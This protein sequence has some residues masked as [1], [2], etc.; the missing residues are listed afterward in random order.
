MRKAQILHRKC[1]LNK[2][3]PKFLITLVSTLV[4]LL[5]KQKKTMQLAAIMHY[6]GDE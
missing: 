1:P 4:P 3:Y 6:V 5:K 2:V